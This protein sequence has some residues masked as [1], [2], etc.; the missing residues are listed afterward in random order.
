MNQVPIDARYQLKETLLNL[1]VLYKNGPRVM[2]VQLSLS[3][4]NFS[5][6]FIQWKNSVDEIIQKLSSDT[7]LIPSL[8][9]YLKVLPEELTDAKKTPISDEDYR[10]QIDEIITKN[11][12]KVLFVLQNC[13]ATA[14]SSFSIQAEVL[15]CLNSWIS[16]TPIE[17]I[18]STPLASLI[19]SALEAPESFESA[20][21]CLCSILR[22]TRDIDNMEVIEALFP[23][24]I[25]LK[26]LL[27]EHQDDPENFKCL[28]RLFVEAGEAWHILIAKMPKDFKPL[29]DIIAKCTAYDED[30]E[31]VKYTFGFWYYLKQIITMAKFKSAR[32]EFADVY[33]GLIDTIIKHLQYPIVKEGEDLFGA[34][35][36]QEDKFKDFRYDMG[37]VLKD[38]CAVVGSSRALKQALSKINDCII[39]QSNG[40]EPHWQSIEAPLFSMRAMAREVSPSE[41]EVLP[42]IMNLLVQLPEHEKIR[43]A[44]TLVLGRYTEWTNEHPEFLEQQLN[45]IINGFSTANSDVMKAAAQAL[46]FFCQDC[47]TL[48]TNYIEQLYT[49]YNGVASQLDVESL[50]EVTD[51]IAHIVAAQDYSNISRAAEMFLKPI[52]GRLQEKVKA[53]ASEETRTAIAD[54]VELLT[55][56]VRVIK[57]ETLPDSS[58]NPMATLVIQIFPIISLLLQNHGQSAKVSERCLKF[59]KYSMHSYGRFLD[60]ILPDIAQTLISGF[61]ATHFGCYLWVTGTVIREFGD[62]YSDEATQN[63]VW[64][65]TYQQ[66]LNIFRYLNG[67]TPKDIPDVIEDFFRMMADVLMFFPFK[68]I[69]SDLLSPTFQSAMISLNLEQFDPL[70]T[71]L[72]FLIDLI[73]WGFESP[74]ISI[75][76]EVPENIRSIVIL[77]ASNHGS[78]LTSKLLSGL[79]FSFP[80]DTHPDASELLL[81]L[82]KL[83][84]DPNKV[85]E[86]LAH[87]LDYSLPPGTVTSEEKEKLLLTVQTALGS[88]DYK[89][90]RSSIKDFVTWYARRNVTP[91]TQFA[92]AQ[93]DFHFT[94]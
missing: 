27:E 91:R 92:G 44:A 52:V 57:P 32:D 76:D 82:L 88:G 72:H 80:K 9:E 5:L 22:E 25:A 78:D 69:A 20:I 43:Y 15:D 40:Q 6:Q 61:E 73:S 42:I 68:F 49:F 67:V 84:D 12:K 89:R 10:D 48:L 33:L 60:P 31:I 62:E 29:V 26:P 74:P 83:T 1:L 56:F 65:F 38:C 46:M 4:A 45:Y 7:S 58:D 24:I 59:L 71:T 53:P 36:E 39:A 64:A 63:S 55:I 23:R 79:I 16:E 3:L 47:A 66:M 51:G 81:K 19:F 75:F 70:I 8:L 21:D 90:V 13:S 14:T 11:T 35:R 77:F 41:K 85:A 93:Q 2:R 50:Y 54:E 94:D 37:D 28:T 34:D 18:L 17:D 30:L 87:T 86:W